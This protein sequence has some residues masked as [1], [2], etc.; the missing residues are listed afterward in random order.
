MLRFIRAE[1][2]PEAWEG[3]V[4]DCW[5][6]GDEIKTQYD[7]K[8]DPPSRDCM[9]A[10]EIFYPDKEPRIHKC[11]PGDYKDLHK[12]VREVVEGIRNYRIGK[13]GAGWNYTYNDRFHRSPNDVIVAEMLKRV[14][15]ENEPEI[16]NYIAM[17]QQHLLPL[18]ADRPAGIDQIE[19]ML[20]MIAKCPYTRRAQAI[21][22]VPE[23]DTEDEH[24]PCVQRIWGRIVKGD[25]L[26]MHVNIRSNDAY[27][28][29]GMNLFAFSELQKWMASR[30]SAKTGSKIGIGSLV[31][32]A[33]S[34]HIYGSYFEQFKDFLESRE[35]KL[36]PDRVMCSDDPRYL[37]LCAEADEELKKEID[38]VG[39]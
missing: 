33:D 18:N 31:W 32:V 21:T 23:I 28:A 4:L 22:W 14:A 11:F 5:R 6:Y 29:A 10:I 35:R 8:G 30:L 13:H 37:E 25:L 26:E 12:Y 2:I 39:S 27:K 16:R 9:M 3:A 34:F 15:A 7:K 17:I 36:W 20:D 19:T 24:C 1:T 38:E